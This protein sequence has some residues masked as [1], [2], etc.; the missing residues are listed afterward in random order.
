MLLFR[1]SPYDRLKKFGKEDTPEYSSK[2]KQYRKWTIQ[3]LF[4][5]T[6][7]FIIS[8]QENI[9][10]FPKSMCWLVKHIASMLSKTGTLEPKEVSRILINYSFQTHL[11]IFKVK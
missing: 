2:I 9:H 6:N 8:L 5:I 11:F 7:R 10:C 1:F 4:T 3:N